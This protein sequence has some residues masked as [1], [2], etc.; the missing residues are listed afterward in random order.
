MMRRGVIVAFLLCC[1]FAVGCGTSRLPRARVMNA[2]PDSPRLDVLI[3]GGIVGQR[4]PF[5]EASGYDRIPDGF[6]DVQVFAADSNDLLLEDVPFFAERHDYTYVVLDFLQVLNA[7]LL[8]DDNSPPLSGNFK[9][10]FVHASP[11]AGA[12]DVYI[13]VPNA[14]LTSAMPA[15]TNVVFGGFAGYA[16]QPQGTV[17][18]RITPAGTKNVISD[19]GE[20]AFLAGQIR[21]GVLVNPPGSATQPLGI[22]LLR[23]VQ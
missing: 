14:D 20:L 18:L 16:S 8:T 12:V 6:D 4:L 5:R 3:A 9:L 15:F 2:S 13:T 22:V 23:D 19:S 21:T 1:L 7:V 10:R 11:T 17:Q